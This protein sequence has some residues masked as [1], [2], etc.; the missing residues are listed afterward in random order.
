MEKPSLVN[1]H[2]EGIIHEEAMIWIDLEEE[3]FH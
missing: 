1:F 3:E 2:V